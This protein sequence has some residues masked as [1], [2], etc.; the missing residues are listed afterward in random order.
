MMAMTL[1]R[2]HSSGPPVLAGEPVV[3]DWL[4]PEPLTA[5]DQAAMLLFQDAML[6]VLTRALAR[7]KGALEDLRLLGY[8]KVRVEI[9]LQAG[10]W[11]MSRVEVGTMDKA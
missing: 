5:A 3:G 7:R 6:G 1:S 11:K 2:P 4:D 10:R 9:D 8:G